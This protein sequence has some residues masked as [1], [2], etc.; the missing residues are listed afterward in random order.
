MALA[1]KWWQVDGVRNQIISISKAVHFTR[2]NWPSQLPV[3]SVTGEATAVP[4]P[5]RMQWLSRDVRCLASCASS[6]CHIPDVAR[7]ER[8]SDHRGPTLVRIGRKAE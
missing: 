3:F 8:I 4:M 5:E 1:T 2:R 6:P 7:N